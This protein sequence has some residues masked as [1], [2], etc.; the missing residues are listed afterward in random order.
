MSAVRNVV[1]DLDGTL[2][3]SAPAILAG[4]GQAFTRCNVPAVNPL[5]AAIIGPPLMQTL[6][7]LAGN[8]DSETLQRLAAAFKEEYDTEGYK[9][10]F[11]FEGVETLLAQLGASPLHLFIATNKR[12]VPTD[13]IIDLL[14]WRRHFDAVYSLDFFAPD[15]R[16]KGELILRIMQEHRLDPTE[17][18]YIGDRNEDGRAAQMA[19]VRFLLASWGYQESAI[20]GWKIVSEP[21][22]LAAAIADLSG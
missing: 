9:K 20:E 7:Y 16:N 10:T 21:S 4:F 15:T 2:I 14:N 11:V 1:F 22:Q 6:A 18:V 12:Q 19:G 17:T 8:D 3:D 13:K 5:D